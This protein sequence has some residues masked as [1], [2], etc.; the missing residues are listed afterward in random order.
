MICSCS[1]DIA[2]PQAKSPDEL[3]RRIRE[4]I[5]LCLKVEGFSEHNLEVIGDFPQRK[6]PA[7]CRS[8]IENVNS[9]FTGLTGHCRIEADISGL[10]MFSLLHS[11]RMVDWM[12]AALGF[13]VRS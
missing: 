7:R 11:G 13:R 1:G 12:E 6:S 9:R 8:D 3:D 10:I 2:P 5:E 4:A